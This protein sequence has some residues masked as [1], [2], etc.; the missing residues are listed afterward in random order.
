MLNWSTIKTILASKEGPFVV[1]YLLMNSLV[2]FWVVLGLAIFVDAI[3]LG[4]QYA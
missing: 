1:S 4:G 2:V 3:F